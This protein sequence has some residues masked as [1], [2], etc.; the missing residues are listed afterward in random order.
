MATR[1]KSPVEKRDSAPP[2]HIEVITVEKCPAF[3]VGRMLVSTPLD[4]ERVI[5]RVPA[6]SILRLDDLRAFLAAE[7]GADYTCPLTAGIFLRVIAEAAEQENALGE[8]N[9]VPYWRVVR[10]DGRLIEKLPGG[11]AAQA[12]RLAEE[13]VPLTRKGKSIRVTDPALHAWRPATA[14]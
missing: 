2:A 9:E 14:F 7:S 11:E 13:G 12:S 10:M 6:G 4:I 1:K 5:R 8:T 3:P